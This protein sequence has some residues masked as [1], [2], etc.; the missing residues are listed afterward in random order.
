MCKLTI[1]N[2]GKDL[3]SGSHV[4][5]NPAAVMN[6]VDGT[7]F[8]DYAENTAKALTRVMVLHPVAACLSFIAFFLAMGAGVVGSFL[9]SIVATLAFVVTLVVL[10]CDFV[11]LG[12]IKSNVNN[13]NNG[14]FD[15]N[16]YFSVGMWC[17]LV[18]GVCN[19]LAAIVVFLTCCTGR[20]KKRRENRKV[21]HHSHTSP[22]R[23]RR[24]PWQ[25]RARY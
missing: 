6:S 15:S 1:L 25:R 7:D 23:R 8:S 22:P 13:E 10:V 3:C 19:L 21:E 2:S 17:V 5:Y 16:A 11:G 12:V 9:A 24:F 14:R 4:G 18:A 20:M